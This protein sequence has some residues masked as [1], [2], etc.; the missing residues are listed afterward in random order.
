MIGE[1]HPLVEG[2]RSDARVSQREVLEGVIWAATRTGLIEQ[3]RFGTHR[4]PADDALV[5]TRGPTLSSRSHYGQAAGTATSRYPSRLCI[6][7]DAY[8]MAP[9]PRLR[10]SALASRRHETRLGGVS[11]T[12]RSCASSQ[13]R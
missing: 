13:S 6:L 8:K 4:R 1:G 3:G 5:V 11:Q 2:A 10:G 9:A 12:R 7:T